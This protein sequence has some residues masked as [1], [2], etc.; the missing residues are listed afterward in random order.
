MS[1]KRV[2]RY[3]PLV[4]DPERPGKF[5]CRGCKGKVPKGRR[6]WCSDAC[7]E[8][9]CWFN[10]TE[11]V[12]ARDKGHCQR[13]HADLRHAPPYTVEFDH[14]VPL[15]EGGTNTDDN[16]R[17]LCRPCHVIV[18]AEWRRRKAEARERKQERVRIRARRP[19]IIRRQ[20]I[21]LFSGGAK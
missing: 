12:W 3:P 14:I 5:L 1:A 16:L 15:S 7:Y 9:H 11:R 10:V 17:V 2:W 13:C 20:S 21:P 18:T 6:T 19:E 8:K 4:P